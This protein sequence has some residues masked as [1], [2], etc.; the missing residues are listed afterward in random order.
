MEGFDNQI[1]AGTFTAGAFVE[2][3][4]GTGEHFKAALTGG[5][6]TGG[7]D[8]EELDNSGY[9]AENYE[10]QPVEEKDDT[11][12]IRKSEPVAKIGEITYTS[13]AKAVEAAESGDTIL[14]LIDVKLLEAVSVAKDLTLDLAGHKLIS[15]TEKAFTVEEEGKL[16]IADTSEEGMKGSIT[17]EGAADRDD[18]GLIEVKG[19]LVLTGGVLNNA[20]KGSSAVFSDTES[21]I[22]VSGGTIDSVSAGITAENAAVSVTGGIV[23]AGDYAFATGRAEISGQ[24]DVKSGNAVF[25]MPKDAANKITGGTF[26]AAETFLHKEGDTAASAVTISGGTF[27]VGGITAEQ[28]D[29][30]A[31][32]GLEAK[33]TDGVITLKKK[34]DPVAPNPTNPEPSGP[35]TGDNSSNGSGSGSSGGSRRPGSSSSN[36]T[37]EAPVM[38]T[39]AAAVTPQDPAARTTVSAPTAEV[40][41]TADETVAEK[42]QD[43]TVPLAENPVSAEGESEDELEEAVG[44]DDYLNAEDEEVPKAIMAESWALANLLALILAIL[45]GLLGLLKKSESEKKTAVKAA[46][47]LVAAAAAVTFVMTE[48]MSSSMGI[49][50]GWTLLMVLYAAVNGILLNLDEIQKIIKT[51]D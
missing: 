19:E 50:D 6:Y 20:V 33:E 46:G 45:A 22:T 18:S 12:V 32:D 29:K 34:E 25:R 15:Q 48:N 31:A 27:A 42:V 1:S 8:K 43:E 39:P 16:T 30:H 14:L 49:V 36:E 5:T 26:R 13:L 37:A 38:E 7:I 21:S 17:N 11:W 40:P 28:I 44:L 10:V 2:K 47:V 35:N 9:V 51:D 3:E 24:A 23:Q 4:E 41:E